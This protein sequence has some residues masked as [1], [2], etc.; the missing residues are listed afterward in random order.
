MCNRNEVYLL[1]TTNMGKVVPVRSYAP[2]HGT[3]WGGGGCVAP[4][5]CVYPVGRGEWS[6]SYPNCFNPR[7][8]MPSAHWIGGW[9]GPRADLI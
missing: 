2:C 8:L 3:Y 7:E 1:L 5:I 9:I 6:V 4:C